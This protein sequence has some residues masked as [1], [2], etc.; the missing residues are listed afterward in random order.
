MTGPTRRLSAGATSG[1]GHRPLRPDDVLVAQTP[2]RRRRRPAPPRPP[3]QSVRMPSLPSLRLPSLSNLA[4]LRRDLP[5]TA[6]AA[7]GALALR[8]RELT[9]RDI[10]DLE[11]LQEVMSVYYRLA[12]LREQHRNGVYDVD[13]FG[14]DRELTEALMPL[15]RVVARRY[16]RVEV[17]GT[18]HLPRRG[19]ALLVSNHAGVL[20]WDGAMIKV[21]VFDA[22]ER[23]ARALVATWFGELPVASWFLRRTG[24]APGHPDDTHRLLRNGEL[25]LVFPEGVRG[26]GKPWNERYRLRRFGRGGF[27]EAAMRAGVPIVPVSVIGSEE[28]YPMVADVRPLAHLFGMPYFPITPTWPF[29][30]PLGLLPLPSKWR[31]TFHAPVSTLDSDEPPEQSTVMELADS[32]RDTIQMGVVDSLMQRQRVFRG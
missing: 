32:V 12:A 7:T 20:P 30:G 27:V 8:L 29:L 31:I 18:E 3:L 13:D 10:I 9:G 15:F 17:D 6:M 23:H 26:T 14:F 19:G 25:V 2:V 16:W 5:T 28:T 21:A 11:S 1:N 4:A 22:T 24:Q